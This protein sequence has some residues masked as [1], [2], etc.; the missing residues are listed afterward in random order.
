MTARGAIDFD[1][2]PPELRAFVEA[3]RAAR[4]ALEQEVATL[5]EQNRR[6]EHLVREFRQAL[7]GR[8]SEKLSADERQLAFEELEAAVAETEASKAAAVATGSGSRSEGASPRRPLGRLPRELPRELPRIERVLEPASTLCPCGCGEMA[9]IGEDRSERL[10]ITPAQF[11]VIVTVRPKYACRR[12]AGAMVQAMA[13]AHLIEGALPTE[14]LLAH[15]LLAHVL[16]AKYADHLP[17]Y[18]QAQIYARAGVELSR[19][20]LADW[21]GKAAF[22]LRPVVDRLAEH[23]KGSG[24]LFMDETRAPVL[25]PGRGRTK[26]GYLWALARDDRRWGGADP[27]GVVYFYAPG[28]TP[29]VLRPGFY[30]PGSTPRVLR[31]GSRCRACRG[32]AGRVQRR[33]AGGWLQRL[34][35]P[36]RQVARRGAAD[37]GA[38]LG[39]WPAAAPCPVRPGRLASCRGGPAPD[40][41][42]LPD[43]G[44][45]RGPAAR[46][47]PRRAAGARQAPG[48]GV[49]GGAWLAAARARLSPKSRAGEKLTYFAHHWEG[50]LVFLDDGRVEIDTNA[51]E[52]RI[53]PLVL[54]RKNALFAGHDEGARN[55]GRIASLIETAKMN[56]V[57]PAAYL[58]ATL[59]AIARGHPQSRLDELLPWAAT[60]ASS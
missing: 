41:R 16:V 28:S 27:P 19:A 32:D 38:L 5:A 35:D 14:A 1:I 56:G 10:D 4:H 53:R 34:Q 36:G 22:H 37:A 17:L 42:A 29:R 49:R 48:S 21:V 31:P 52:N 60:T 33:A 45:D 7:H 58:T 2:L 6:L 57:D 46:A 39:T 59:E 23:L 12:C 25:D 3:E 24:K 15:V 9:R 50:L 47:A 51:V 26:T 43:R 30:A 44:R 8:K 40:C 13:P 18:R 11:R 55:W 54:S 20:M